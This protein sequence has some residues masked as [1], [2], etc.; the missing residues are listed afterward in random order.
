MSSRNLAYMTAPE[1]PPPRIPCAGAPAS[2]LRLS[3]SSRTAIELPVGDIVGDFLAAALG[4]ADEL[5]MRI[6]CAVHEAV[7]NAALHGNLA[8]ANEGRDHAAR[9]DEFAAAIA[10]RLADPALAARRCQ[11]RVRWTAATVLVRIT[12]Q[13]AGFAAA[14]M[15]DPALPWGRGIPVIKA[16][17]TRCRWVRGGRSLMLR[18][19]R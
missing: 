14:G 1:R 18:F 7:L 6:T 8:L 17:T 3:L 9:G 15:P 10:A 11:I 2:P 16:L 4:L 12:D 13:G 5:R 19:A